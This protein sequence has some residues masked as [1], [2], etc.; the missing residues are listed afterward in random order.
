MCLIIRR[1]F[2]AMKF[3]KQRKAISTWIKL[4]IYALPSSIYL[5]HTELFNTELGAHRAKKSCEIFW[6]IK[7]LLGHKRGTCKRGKKIITYIL[8]FPKG[9]TTST[10]ST[11]LSTLQKCQNIQ[12]KICLSHL[13][14]WCPESYHA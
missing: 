4:H 13:S 8:H 7:I 6:A 12:K 3:S 1:V 11:S 5:K 14:K 2:G 10:F 9:N